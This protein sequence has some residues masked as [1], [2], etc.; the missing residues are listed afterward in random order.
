M[1]QAGEVACCG[2]LAGIGQ[3]VRIAEGACCSCRARAPSRFM[4]AAKPETLPPICSATTTATSL[5][6]FVTS[7]RIASST[8]M[9]VPAFTPSLDGGLLRR[10]RRNCKLGRKG[11]PLRLELLEEH[12]KRH[13]LGQRRRVAPGV[14]V[15][16]KECFPGI[17]RRSP[18]A[19]YLFSAALAGWVNADS[20]RRNTARIG[21]RSQRA[22]PDTQRGTPLKTEPLGGLE[23]RRAAPPMKMVSLAKNLGVTIQ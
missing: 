12:V 1:R 2:D 3:A 16:G 9:V 13:H 4:R 21:R 14:G 10:V 6:D 5:A 23:P 11:E 20:E 18:V 7:A 8:L 22:C 19:A 17:S 15:L